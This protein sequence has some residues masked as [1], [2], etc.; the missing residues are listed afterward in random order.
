MADPRKAPRPRR[1]RPES[2]SMDDGLTTV[3]LVQTGQISQEEGE[4]R[5]DKMN[6]RIRETNDRGRRG[7]FRLGNDGA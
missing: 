7:A 6:R 4:R 1:P 5:I 2:R 3:Q